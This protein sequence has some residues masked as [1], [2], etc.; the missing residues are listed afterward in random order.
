MSRE[1]WQATVHR[2]DEA[3]EH[4]RAH[5]LERPYLCR[6]REQTYGLGQGK[7]AGRSGMKGE[8]SIETYTLPYVNR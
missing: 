4:S 6:H 3:P 8:C 7:G 5:L 1:A 2:V